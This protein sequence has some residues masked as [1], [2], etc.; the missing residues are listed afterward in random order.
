[1]VPKIQG[2]FRLDDQNVMWPERKTND[3]ANELMM[4]SSEHKMRFVFVFA[5][6]DFFPFR[7]IIKANVMKFYPFITLKD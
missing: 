1:M 5:R 2:D 3:T 7:S 4:V 6:A